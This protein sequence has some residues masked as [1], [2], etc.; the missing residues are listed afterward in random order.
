MFKGVT[1]RYGDAKSMD[2]LVLD[3]LNCGCGNAPEQSSHSRRQCD[4]ILPTTE[5]TEVDP[6]L[7]TRQE[8]M[9]NGAVEVS[10]LG[11]EASG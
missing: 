4:S 7:H 1:E 10:L 11:L 6:H 9:D 3:A 8:Y 5:G 2:I